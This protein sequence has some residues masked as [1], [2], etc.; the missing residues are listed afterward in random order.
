VVLLRRVAVRGSM[1]LSRLSE[2]N[3]RPPQSIAVK[4]ARKQL[5]AALE[6]V[7]AAEVKP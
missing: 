7:E 2:Q 6:A 3:P 4:L 1:L 5:Q